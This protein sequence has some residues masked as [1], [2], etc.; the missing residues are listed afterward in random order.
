VDDI[1]VT[2]AVKPEKNPNKYSAVPPT[3]LEQM[4][5]S[6]YLLLCAWFSVCLIPLQY[7]VGSIGFQ[8]EEM[9]D[10]DG[11]YTDLFSILYASAIVFSPAGGFLSDKLS[12]G[13]TQALATWL[14]AASFFLL[15]SDVSLDAQA[16]GLLFYGVGRLLVFGMYFAN[17]GKR[18]GY[19]N[20]GTLAGLGLLVSALVSLLQYP[21]ISGAAHGHSRMINIGS[22]I[23]LLLQTP[24]FVWLHR[25]ERI[26]LS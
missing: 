16:I 11:F 19:T 8:L 2:H 23:A 10:D 21:M 20:F 24:Y 6:E 18:F 9:G 17:C 1:H 13:V 12:L 25:R 4:K 26:K 14:C 15:A 3:A 5:S 22:G 7:Y